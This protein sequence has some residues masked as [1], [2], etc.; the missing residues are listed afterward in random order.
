MYLSIFIVVGLLFSS[1]STPLLH[2]RARGD[3][4]LGQAELQSQLFAAALPDHLIG[5]VPW[6]QLLVPSFRLY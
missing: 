4:E 3:Q 5:I 2:N 6:N 1:A